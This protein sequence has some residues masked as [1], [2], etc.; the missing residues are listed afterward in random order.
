VGR[1]NIQQEEE[2]V[3]QP[4]AWRGRQRQAARKRDGSN[5][6]IASLKNTCEVSNTCRTVGKLTLK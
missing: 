3:E 1:N 2:E 4:S 6:P 5:I